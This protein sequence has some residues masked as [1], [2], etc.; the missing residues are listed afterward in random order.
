[1]PTRPLVLTA[2]ALALVL[3]GCGGSGDGD[4]GGGQATPTGATTGGGDG[5]GDGD[6]DASG[7]GDP[8]AGQ[9]VWFEQGCVNC[10]ELA[11]AGI[12]AT[13]R[14]GVVGPNLDESKPSY[15]LVVERVTNGKGQMPAL[16][17]GMTPADIQNVA[18]Y[19]SSVAGK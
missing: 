18:A 9:L 2:L 16:A 10:H 6:G 3:P 4:D 7:Q 12:G 13:G 5:D 11:D 8:K 14:A 1:V 15:E 17:D 19:V